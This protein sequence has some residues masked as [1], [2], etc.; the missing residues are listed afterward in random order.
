MKCS[1]IKT[2]CERYLNKELEEFTFSLTR[3]H[4]SKCLTCKLYFREASDIANLLR[5]SLFPVTV[6]SEFTD[7]VMETIYEEPIF[8]DP[9]PDNFSPDPNPIPFYYANNSPISPEWQKGWTSWK[10]WRDLWVTI[11][12]YSHDFYLKSSMYHHGEEYNAG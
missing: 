6:G 4:L 8:S 5:K 10:P 2:Y 9:E 1:A 3:K 12:N 7:R 11:G